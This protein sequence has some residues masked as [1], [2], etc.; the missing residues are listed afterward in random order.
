MLLILKVVDVVMIVLPFIC[1]LL[2][3][4]FFT[5]FERKVLAA[6]MIRK[7]PNK[8]GYMG[9][10]QPFSDAG[11]L[12][13]KEFVYPNRANVMPFFFAPSLMLGVSMSLWILYPLN[14]VD[15]VF[16]FGALQF[17]VTAGVSVF[18]VMMA[19]WASNSKYALLGSVRSIAQSISY[20]IPFCLIL[21]SVA[22]FILTFMFQEIMLWQ[23]SFF[24]LCSLY[25]SGISL[26]LISILAENHRAPFDFVEGESELVSGFNVEYSGGG[27]AMIFMSEY[28]SMMFSS[29][30]TSVMFFGGSELLVSFLSLFFIYF[31]VW[32]R[33]TFPRMRY[34]KLM[35]LGWTIFTIVPLVYLMAI[36][37]VG[38]VN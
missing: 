5:L 28:S 37:V 16:V 11:K 17:M 6:I 24:V 18:G 8:V 22:V 12:F 32:I 20:E 35:Y 3:V 30:V 36:V 10:L 27:F 33:G 2:A 25:L 19:G 34:D 29:I 38:Y 23:E 21:F 7:G 9:L 14:F 13:C 26:W 31:F 4:G 1:V 15:M